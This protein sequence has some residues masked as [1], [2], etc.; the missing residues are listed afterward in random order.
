MASAACGRHGWEV[1]N[2]TPG[3][4]A[5]SVQTTFQH[6]PLNRVTGQVFAG[7]GL[8]VSAWPHGQ[9][10]FPDRNP[11]HNQEIIRDQVAATKS[12]TCAEVP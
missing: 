5:S 11:L 7:R 9:P 10:H 8:H 4:Q 12:R 1:T 2:F 3:S 6:D